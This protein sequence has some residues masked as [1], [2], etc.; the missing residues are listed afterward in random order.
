MFDRIIQASLAYRPL[1]LVIAI[2]LFIYGAVIIPKQPLDVL[3]DLNKTTVTIFTEAGRYSP[4]EVETLVTRPIEQAVNG[5]NGVTRVRSYTGLGLSIIWVEFAYGQ[6][7]Y[8]ARQIVGEKLQLITTELP[9]GLSP[10]LGPIS[11]LMGE[12]LLVG[13]SSDNPGIGELELREMA[14]WDIRRRLLSVPGVAVV[15]A[16]GGN[17]TEFQVLVDPAKLRQY[18]L[19]LQ[20]LEEALE[21]SSANATGGFVFEP[22]RESLVRI[23]GRVQ[24]IDD[25]ASSVIPHTGAPGE[26]PISIGDVAEV[27]KSGALGKLG[28]AG[29]NGESAVLLS[30]Q[31]QPGGDTLGITEA[32][33]EE[34]EAIQETLPEGVTI[35]PD[36][37]RQSVF[38]E[39]GIHNVVEALRDGAIMVAIILVVFLFNLRTTFITLTAI[40]L[41][42][43]VT[44]IVFQIAREGFGFTTLTINTMTLGGLAVAIGELV[45]DAI[46]DVENVF[47]RLRQNRQKDQPKPTLEVVF[48]ASKEIRNSVVYA[49]AIVV[50]V[51]VPLFALGGVEGRIFTPLGIAYIVSIVASLFI[52]L[53]V[54]PVLCSYLLPRMKVMASEK[55]TIFVRVIKGLE[56]ALLRWA[57]PRSYVVIAATVLLLAVAVACLPF[58]GRTFLPE[59]NEGSATIN[60]ILPPGTSL[61]ESSR[62]GRLAEKLLLEVP[63]IEKTGRRVGRAELDDHV[64]AVNSNEIEVEFQDRGRS[65]EEVLRDI[66][67]HLDKIP[68]VTLGVGQ[69][70]SHRIEHIL[71]GV[72]SQMA[73]KIFGDDLIQLRETAETIE[74]AIEDVDGLVDLKVENQALI[75]Q[76][77]VEIDRDRALRYGVTVGD[78]SRYVELALQGRPVSEVLLEGRS[79]PVVLRLTDEDRNSAESIRNLPLPSAGGNLVPLHFV[80]DVEPV[81]GFDRIQRENVQR[82]IL[83]LA[84]FEGRDPHSIMTD[85]KAAVDREVELPDGYYLAYEGQFESQSKATRQI[86]L[87]SMLSLVGMALLLYLHFGSVALTIQVMLNIPFALIG[88]VAVLV[89]TDG[90]FSVATMIGFITLTG[91]AS[92]NGILMIGHYL[93]LMRD[94]GMKFD[95][96]TVIR[97][98]QERLVPVLMTALTAILALSPIVW[99]GDKPG[100]EIIYPVALVISSGLVSSTLL[101]FFVTPAVFWKFSRGAVRNLVP[102]ALEKE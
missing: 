18:D 61:A 58:M 3:P 62:M 51:F 63:E 87:L 13:V 34:L 33:V 14:E 59:F 5:A 45:D 93:H 102:A 35:H 95:E 31:K 40:P 28:D 36:I 86:L 17:E 22:Y 37:F 50:L 64:M 2:V 42:L 57:L 91:I 26:A 46:V 30:V 97:G 100:R 56:A 80:A 84:N 66:R 71:S 12:I 90:I 6:D 68:G 10:V 23:K 92:R 15:T 65:R 88:A 53:T 75:P 76:I 54:T 43:V 9:A 38:I 83:V 44:A 60:V 79:Y 25:I 48:R 52:S 19:T 7:V 72:E 74:H 94:E 73:I 55:D 21:A 98:T 85:V 81:K 39:R 82:R 41:S 77:H 1:V 4:E 67:D 29:V 20:D 99:G 16:M 8:K 96:A 101:A 27:R 69:P 70:I 11:S 89:F 32:V 78:A 49:T 24:S 47:R